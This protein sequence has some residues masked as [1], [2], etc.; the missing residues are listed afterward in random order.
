MSEI[1]RLPRLL[2]D[3]EAAERLSLSIDTLRRMVRRGE[4]GS[5]KFG[6]KRRFTES[7]IAAFLER[8]ECHPNNQSGHTEDSS[9]PSAT[10]RRT[11][12]DA[13]LTPKPGRRVPPPS[14]LAISAK[15][16]AG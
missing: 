1:A 7:Q 10:T 12:I 16:S 6:R 8:M 13:G 5:Y 14:A 3:R 15:L 2:T 4:I 9:C 11:G